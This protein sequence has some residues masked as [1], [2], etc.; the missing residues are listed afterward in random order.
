M[1]KNSC[2]FHL[3]FFFSS[4][5]RKVS[6]TANAEGNVHLESLESMIK[7][8]S[9]EFQEVIEKKAFDDQFS[10]SIHQVEQLS[11]KFKR[12]KLTSA[13]QHRCNL[14]TRFFTNG[15]TLTKH[16]VDIHGNTLFCDVCPKYFT[17]KNLLRD[18]MKY[19]RAK[20]FACNVCD[21]KSAIIQV[22]RRHKMKH[23]LKEVCKICDKQVSSLKIH[24]QRA[25]RAKKVCLVCEKMVTE[26]KMKRHLGT[27]DDIRNKCKD[28]GDTFI[29]HEALRK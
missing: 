23:N 18:H 11:R 4:N 21:Y 3:N 16:L 5:R 8:E 28:C 7:L 26:N 24:L 29:T 1:L 2:Y 25:H 22:L 13:N 15:D 17:D 12:H 6:L 9:P 19:H 14:C 20:T 27:H 10:L